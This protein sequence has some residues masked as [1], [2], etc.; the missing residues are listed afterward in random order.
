MRRLQVA[1]AAWSAGEAAY[2]VAVFVFAFNIGGPGAVAFVAILRTAPSVVLAPLITTLGGARRADDL[3][4]WTLSVRL[5]SVILAGIAMVVDMPA[6]V[7]YGLVAI[8]AVAATLLRPI[9]GS[10]L[11]AIAR[12]PAELVTGNVAMTTGDSLAAL[13]GPTLAAAVLVVGGTAAPFV[14]AIAL[15]TVSTVIGFGIRGAQPLLAG[16]SRARPGDATTPDASRPE[17]T[18]IG[19][20]VPKRWRLDRSTL[21]VDGLHRDP[22]HGPR[23]HHRPARRGGDRLPRAWVIRV[24][25]C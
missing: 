18:P 15:L 19:G 5:A 21:A 8:D 14:P 23:R 11:P 3:L 4:H 6:L 22:A 13:V 16:R 1:S 7:V 10:L 25:V 2:L 12:T 17:G 9:R 24:S 20:I